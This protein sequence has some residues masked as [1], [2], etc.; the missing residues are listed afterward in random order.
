[1]SASFKRRNSSVLI[2]SL[3]LGAALCLTLGASPSEAQESGRQRM[4]AAPDNTMCPVLT[5][6]AIDPDVFT[7]YQERRVYFCCADCKRK[8]ERHAAAYV[9]NLPAGYFAAVAAGAPVQDHDER[10]VEAHDHDAHEQQKAE[11]YGL[12]R[13]FAWLGKFHPLAV[14]FPIAMVM[15]AVLAELMLMITRQPWYGSAARFGVW[16]GGAM[17]LIA[18]VLGWLMAG[19]QLDD[20]SGIMTAH[21]WI[22]TGAALWAVIIIVLCRR[23]YC[24]P[25][26]TRGIMRSYRVALLVGALAVALNGFLGGALVYGLDHFAW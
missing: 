1:M 4:Q 17:A 3:L 26:G 23:A 11:V 18:A 22:G 6:E 12:P 7:V 19:I 21:R 14:H 20:P 5:D 13:V 16:A 9:G 15:S 24:D 25:R 10:I 8:F 2:L